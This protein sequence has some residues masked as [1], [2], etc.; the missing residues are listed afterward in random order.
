MVSPS[1]LYRSSVTA[2]SDI[3]F[4]L[5]HDDMWFES[6]DVFF[7]DNAAFMGDLRDQDVLMNAGDIYYLQHP[8]N[9]ANFFFKNAVAG[10]NTR[11]VVAGILLTDIRKR[12]LGIRVD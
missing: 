4:K 8:A 3:P 12:E 11:V 6:V 2:T 5:V 1:V 9:L 10:S 7:Y